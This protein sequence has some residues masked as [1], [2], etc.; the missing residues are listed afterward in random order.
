MLSYDSAVPLPGQQPKSELVVN[1]MGS[2]ITPTPVTNFNSTMAA[3]APPSKYNHHHIWLVTGPAGCGKTSVAEHLAN[4]LSMPYIEG[5]SFHTPANVEKMRTGTPLTDADRWDW[6]TALREES[7]HRIHGGS[8]GVV[9]TCSALKRKYRDVIRVA[10]Y[11][12]PQLLIHFIYLD[13]SEEMLLKRVAAR[14]N[15]Y[16]GANMVHSQFADLERPL[17]DE[18]DVIKVDVNQTLDGVKAEAASQVLELMNRD[19]KTE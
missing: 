10:A 18:K 4:V 8:D 16:M 15:H 5:D 2:Q 14:Q 3:A 13:A 12:D 17:D 19:V 1:G 6:L 7:M 11:Y 9:L